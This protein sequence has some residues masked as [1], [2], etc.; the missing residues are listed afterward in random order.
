MA[1][2]KNNVEALKFEQAIEQLEQLIEQIESGELGLEESLTQ[3]ERGMAL[4]DRCR[5]V[6]SS[7]EQRIAELTVTPQG[8]LEAVGEAEASDLAPLEAELEEEEEDD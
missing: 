5:Q 7:A 4:I 8:G 3:Y 2:G 1:K 6:L